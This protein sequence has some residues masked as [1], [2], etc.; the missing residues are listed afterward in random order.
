M[1]RKEALDAAIAS[2]RWGA[3]IGM[4]PEM[5]TAQARV[6]EL[7]LGI[8]DRLPIEEE[9]I[10]EPFV[11]PVAEGDEAAVTAICGHR[12]TAWLVHGRWVHLDLTE[13]D[14]PPVK[15]AER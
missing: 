8:A 15:G 9:I 4:S 1:I 6:G 14:D 12:I 10:P 11:P 7:W 3:Q 5:I 13:C 2:A